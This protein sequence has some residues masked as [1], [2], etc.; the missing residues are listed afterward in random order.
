[1]SKSHK[2]LVIII[3]GLLL[4]AIGFFVHLTNRYR[5]LLIVIGFII[6]ITGMVIYRQNKLLLI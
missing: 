5:L 1:M 2:S 3:I 6:Q 4:I